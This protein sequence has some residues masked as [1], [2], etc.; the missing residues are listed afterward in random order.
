MTI[1]ALTEFLDNKKFNYNTHTKRYR[2]E[3]Y[4]NIPRGKI[5][6]NNYESFIYINYKGQIR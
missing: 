3:G 6:K 4:Y 1:Q 5:V 2:K